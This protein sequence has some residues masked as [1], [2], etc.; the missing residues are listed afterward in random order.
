MYRELNCFGTNFAQFDCSITF[1]ILKQFSSQASWRQLRP[2]HAVGHRRTILC[3][4]RTQGNLEEKRPNPNVTRHN[5]KV[6]AS[7]PF[8]RVSNNTGLIV[9][10]GESSGPITNAN[11]SVDTNVDVASAG[12]AGVVY[13]IVDGPHR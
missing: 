9:Q 13:E 5:F 3:Q 10:R 11:L 7:P 4:H 1:I 8:V 2:D 6:R 12:A